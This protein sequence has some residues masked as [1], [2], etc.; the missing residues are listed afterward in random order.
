MRALMLLLVASSAYADSSVN[1]ADAFEPTKCTMNDGPLR[2]DWSA[3]DIKK[4][5]P[6]GTHLYQAAGK[7][8]LLFSSGYFDKP[9]KSVVVER[10]SGKTVMTL[11]KVSRS[12][13]V[14]DASGKL[15][16]LLALRE[17]GEAPAHL[18]LHT[19][20][21]KEAWPAQPLVDRFND[22]A[23]ALVTGDLLIIAFFHRIATGSSLYAFDLKT[24][25]KTWQAEVQQLN[26]GHSKYWNDVSL[27][28]RGATVVMRGFEAAGCYQQIF[29]VATG[30]RLSAVM[31]KTGWN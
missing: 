14:E 11:E 7:K 13:V 6:K 15:L 30:K 29:D 2:K 8:H 19:P 26:V 3:A 20:D 1:G 17:V 10:K 16:G 24:G 5:E 25:A 18:M 22:S 9:A 23:T 4:L 31:P 12:A 28:L 21:G 27:E